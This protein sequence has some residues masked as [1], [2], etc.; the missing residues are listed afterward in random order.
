VSKRFWI[1][2]LV[3]ALFL[4]WNIQ[5]FFKIMAI[6][7]RKVTFH[8]ELGWVDWGHAN[9]D[10][11]TIFL[12]QIDAAIQ[13]KTALSDTIV[14]R[15][16]MYMSTMRAYVQQHFVMDS[17]NE[18]NKLKAS[19]EIFESVSNGFETLQKRFPFI[20]ASSFATEDMNGNKISFYCAY[21]HLKVND[22]KQKLSEKSFFET[23]YQVILHDIFAQNAAIVPTEN[24]D[25]QAYFQFY[26]A[27]E[28]MK[29]VDMKCIQTIQQF[30][31]LKYQIDL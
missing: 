18:S 27:L 31:I 28:K 8:E 7:E 19:F 12:A 30:E 14:Y 16:G 10:G 4:L 6:Y 13:H 22:F 21:K 26:E 3:F 23:F 15:Q 24:A 17:L 1:F 9:T 25:L 5:F 20:S 2:F 11:A 29:R